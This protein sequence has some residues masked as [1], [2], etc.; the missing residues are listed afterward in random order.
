MKAVSQAS[1]HVVNLIMRMRNTV[2]RR[3]AYASLGGYC[4]GR[5]FVVSSFP[6]LVGIKTIYRCK[7]LHAG[8]TV[9]GGRRSEGKPANHYSLHDKIHLSK[10]RSGTLPLQHLEII[11]V[12]RLAFV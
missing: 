4:L 3:F 2:K 12:I 1:V 10:R 8:N 6:S 9:L 5:P 11:A 7:R